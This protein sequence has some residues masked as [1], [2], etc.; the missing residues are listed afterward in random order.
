MLDNTSPKVACSGVP[1]G[2][3]SLALTVVDPD[4]SGFVH[5][6]VWN[7]ARDSTGLAAGVPGDSDPAG[8]ARHALNDFAPFV[9]PG[10]LGPGGAPFK[11]IGHDGPYR[12]AVHTYRFAIY[13]LTS[14]IDL[15]G[16]SPAAEILGAIE[17]GRADGSLIAEATITGRSG[18][19]G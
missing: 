10:E 9:E 14:A 11:T 19:E 6:V 2:T 3:T 17:A 18:P 1:G 15:P 7:I 13:A 16:G 5:R 8:G 4:A 12:G